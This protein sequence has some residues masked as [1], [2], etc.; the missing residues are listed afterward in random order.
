MNNS[1]QWKL[2]G[3]CDICR[4]SNYCSK[5]CTVAKKKSNKELYNHVASAMFA[6]LAGRLDEEI[7][8]KGIHLDE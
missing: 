4:R 3:N 7:K 6:S 5:P 8:E 2:E 1:E